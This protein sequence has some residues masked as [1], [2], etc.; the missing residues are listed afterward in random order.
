MACR[1]AKVPPAPLQLGI[2]HL[3][4]PPWRTRVGQLL[5]SAL[6]QDPNPLS[7]QFYMR[8]TSRT[9][10]RTQRSTTYSI[11]SSTA[12]R[13]TMQV[14]SIRPNGFP[15]AKGTSRCSAQPSSKIPAVPTLPHHKAP[16]DA[17]RSFFAKT[18]RRRNYNKAFAAVSERRH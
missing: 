11:V 10:I 13:T 15:V 1:T 18:R 3:R 5:R 4:Q 2:G 14:A 17:H 6:G 9:A 8:S 16:A 12:T 7:N